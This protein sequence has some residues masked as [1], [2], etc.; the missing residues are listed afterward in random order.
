VPSFTTCILRLRLSWPQCSAHMRC[1]SRMHRKTRWRCCGEGWRGEGTRN[2]DPPS[3]PSRDV[4][5][6]NLV[7]HSGVCIFRVSKRTE[8]A[9][10]TMTLH[11]M[12]D[13]GIEDR[14]PGNVDISLFATYTRPAVRHNGFPIRRIRGAVS[15]CYSGRG[16]KLC[17]G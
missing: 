15:P 16:F 3:S 9:D 11:A 8:L 14:F 2:T 10:I 6:S 5:A 13:Q 1:S 17:A 7:S 12:H 4:V